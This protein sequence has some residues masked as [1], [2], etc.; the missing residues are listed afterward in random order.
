MQ[1]GRD[2]MTGITNFVITQAV[3][4]VHD[5]PIVGCL[6]LIAVQGAIILLV[7]LIDTAAAIIPHVTVATLAYHALQDFDPT[8]VRGMIVDA[9]FLARIPT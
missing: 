3:L 8:A 5:F 4:H 7:L 1:G 6:I 9:R 2:T